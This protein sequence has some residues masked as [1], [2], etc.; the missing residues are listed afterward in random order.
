[1]DALYNIQSTRVHLI[2]IFLFGLKKRESEEKPLIMR[3]FIMRESEAEDYQICEKNI[4]I[5]I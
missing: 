1:M 5:G 2:D 3:S 4:E